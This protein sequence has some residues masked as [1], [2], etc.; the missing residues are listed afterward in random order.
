MTTGTVLAFTATGI[1][2]LVA[3]VG[4]IW[5]EAQMPDPQQ[6]R[7]RPPSHLGQPHPATMFAAGH[8]GKSSRTSLGWAHHPGRHAR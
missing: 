8:P 7:P 1:I 2:A 5:L 4:A 6:Q 3:I